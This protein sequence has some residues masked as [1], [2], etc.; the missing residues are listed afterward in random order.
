M[1]YLPSEMPKL[2]EGRRSE[3]CSLAYGR[4]YS[5]G[6][7]CRSE[8]FKAMRGCQEFVQGCAKREEVRCMRRKIYKDCSMWD[9]EELRRPIIT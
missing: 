6:V 5:E 2:E 9:A 4:R 7:I 3:S 8:L 1:S